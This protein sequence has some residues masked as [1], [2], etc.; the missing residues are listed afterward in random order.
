MILFITD[1][2]NHVQIS[3]RAKTRLDYVIEM[4]KLG[5]IECDKSV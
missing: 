4:D 2:S 3:A 5:M 1:F